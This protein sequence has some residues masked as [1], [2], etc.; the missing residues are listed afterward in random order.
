MCL[1]IFSWQPEMDYSLILAANR[2]EFYS[3]PTR[4][5]HHWEDNPDILGGRDDQGQGSWLAVNRQGKIA[6]ITNYREVPAINS[7]QSRGQLVS[8]FLRKNIK[9]TDYLSLIKSQDTFYAGFNLLIGDQTGLHYYSNRSQQAFSLQPGVYGLSNHLL[10]TPWPKLQKATNQ[11]ARLLRSN[12]YNPPV[13][14]LLKLMNDTAKPSDAELPDTGIGLE[15]ERLLSSCFI[16]SKNYGT[17]NTS[18]LKWSSQGRLDWY[19]HLFEPQGRP[20]RKLTF[21]LQLLSG[22]GG[23][24]N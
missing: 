8:D 4:P 15:K 1:I 14:S 23:V 24:L 6:A 9:A 18:I 5:L 21:S 11:L 17:R 12:Q 16:K 3:R 7:Q 13:A 10:N 22:L 20:G 19:E 2:D